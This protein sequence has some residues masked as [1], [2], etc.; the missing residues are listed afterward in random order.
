MFKNVILN[1]FNCNSNWFSELFYLR[2]TYMTFLF[3]EFFVCYWG[4][5][6]VFEILKMSFLL[7]FNYNN[8][9]FSF[10]HLRPPYMSSFF[11]F[12]WG[13]C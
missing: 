4:H 8:S 10:F 5:L 9:L 7:S 11:L 12:Y 13:N 1:T 3:I 6:R 2:P